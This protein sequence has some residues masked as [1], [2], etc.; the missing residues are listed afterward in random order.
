MLGLI[1]SLLASAVPAFPSASVTCADGPASCDAASVSLA[2]PAPAPVEAPRV[3]ATPAVI[4][5]RGTVVP[6]VLQTLVGECDGVPRDASYR[7]SR[8]PENE[9][10]GLAMTPARQ[11][12]DARPAT[13]CDGL[14]PAGGD[15]TVSSIQPIALFAV[16]MLIEEAGAAVPPESA[17]HFRLRPRD[18]LDRPPRA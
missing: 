13:S 2:A 14:P 3:Y 9:D 4:D 1:V 17:F 16:P 12:R 5:C 10:S 8:Y 6:T 15:L 18:R 7:V 11:A